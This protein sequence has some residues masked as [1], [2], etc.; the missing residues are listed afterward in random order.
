MM[1]SE[2]KIAAVPSPLRAWLALVAIS[3]RRQARMR[4]MVWIAL[5]LLALVLVNILGGRYFAARNAAAYQ[6][7]SLGPAA[8]QARYGDPWS[9][10]SWRHPRRIGPTYGDISID[11]LALGES[12]PLPPE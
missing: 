5:G 8:T 7:Q 12:A 4:Q 10:L 6:P 2:T 1:G 3:V 9:L 11:F